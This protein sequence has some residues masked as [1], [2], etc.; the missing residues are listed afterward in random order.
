MR[1]QDHSNFLGQDAYQ[2]FVTLCVSLCTLC[3]S[4]GGKGF[5]KLIGGA[6]LIICGEGGCRIPSSLGKFEFNQEAS[7]PHCLP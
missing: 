5:Q 7:D 2:G 6:I 3:G 4:L 1:I